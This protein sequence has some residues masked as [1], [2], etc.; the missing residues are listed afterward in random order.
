MLHFT[1]FHA[2]MAR[3][4]FI[5]RT[6]FDTAEKQQFFYKCT[7]CSV[8]DPFRNGSKNSLHPDFLSFLNRAAE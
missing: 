5:Q 4:N 1:F 7:P 2:K 3:E 6:H 8:G